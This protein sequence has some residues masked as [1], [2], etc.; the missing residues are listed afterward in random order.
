[1]NNLSP[2]VCAGWSRISGRGILKEDAAHAEW[3]RNAICAVIL[4]CCIVSVAQ[5]AEILGTAHVIDGDTIDIGPVRIRLHG[6]DAP[7]SDQS[8]ATAANGVWDCGAVATRRLRL[9]VEN[10]PIRC[11]ARDRDLYGRVIGVCFKGDEDLNALLVREGLAWAY[12]R[13]SNDYA[14]VEATARLERIGI[15]GAENIPPWEFRAQRW[16]RAAAASPRPGCPIKGNINRDG[17]RIY[18]TPWSRW[19]ERVQIDESQGD[20]WFCD[21]AEAQAA[22]WR[23]PR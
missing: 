13:F 20:L 8:C 22:G 21:E 7:E 12:T 15:W 10:Q 1:M 2:L 23:A 16:E 3:S 17:D 14:A 19:Y 4:C 5:S 6:I 18:H 11:E 9:S